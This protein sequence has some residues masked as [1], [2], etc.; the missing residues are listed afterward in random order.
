MKIGAKGLSSKNMVL[1]EVKSSDSSVDSDEDKDIIDQNLFK[2]FDFILPHKRS[3]E[4]NRTHK[5]K[6]KTRK[7]YQIENLRTKI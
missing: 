4:T 1:V 7:F 5:N 6:P 2:G 3:K